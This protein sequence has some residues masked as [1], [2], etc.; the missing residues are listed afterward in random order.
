M[1]LFLSQDKNKLNTEDREPVTLPHLNHKF[2]SST[3]DLHGNYSRRLKYQNKTSSC[4]FP[5]KK[6]GSST[7]KSGQSRT[8]ASKMQQSLTDFS[9]QDFNK[10]GWSSIHNYNTP[11]KLT[12]YP[13][14]KSNSVIDYSIFKG[15][16]FGSSLYSKTNDKRMRQRE[17]SSAIFYSTHQKMPRA[18]LKRITEKDLSITQNG[19][20]FQMLGPHNSQSMSHSQS[21]Q[22][23]YNDHPK[24]F[25]IQS[26][27]DNSQQWETNMEIFK[28]TP[29]L[30]PMSYTRGYLY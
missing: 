4:F 10:S 16:N 1:S 21:Q 14:V 5:A 29:R 7:R 15:D 28:T 27:Q 8:M 23:L 26:L 25:H 22:F 9:G 12:K 18:H 30:D 20:Y 2:Y 24:M 19:N 6:L 3:F 11:V 13:K 17:R